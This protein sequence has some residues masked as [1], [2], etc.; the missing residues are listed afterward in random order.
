MK[1]RNG[2]LSLREGS[3]E[4]LSGLPNGVLGYKRNCDAKSLIVLL[5]FDKREKEFQIE[6]AE[7]IFALSDQDIAKEKFIYLSGFG[8]VIL[9]K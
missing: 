3:L 1:V 7:L 5:N 2:E 6:F 8:G 9:K 4:T